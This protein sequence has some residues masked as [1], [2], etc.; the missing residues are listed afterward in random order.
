MIKL[1][2]ESWQARIGAFKALVYNHIIFII[3]DKSTS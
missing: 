1:K 2:T 3:D